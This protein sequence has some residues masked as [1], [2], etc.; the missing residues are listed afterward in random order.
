MTWW[1]GKYLL[2]RRVEI[3]AYAGDIPAGED[4]SVPLD[5]EQFIDMNKVRSD[6][7]DIEVLY[8]SDDDLA[9]PPATPTYIVMSRKVDLNSVTFPLQVDIEKG[10]VSS[11][12]YWIYYGNPERINAPLRSAYI[13][14]PWPIQVEADNDQITYTRPGEHWVDGR[15]SIPNAKATFN[16]TGS[17]IRLISEYGPNQGKMNVAIDDV[18]VQTVDLFYPTTV[19]QVAFSIQGLL[20]KDHKIQVFATNEKSPQSIGYE[21]NISRFEYAESY[22]ST[23]G[24]EDYFASNWVAYSGG[25]T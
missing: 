10:D 25:Q 18:V 15:S 16:F 22:H 9:T 1:N 14:N 12:E 23:D 6:F 20:D 7:E 4:I 8:Q 17:N 2:R 11:G 5:I 13:D 24:G 3:E 21:V 19:T